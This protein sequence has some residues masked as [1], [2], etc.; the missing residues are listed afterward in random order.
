[1]LPKRID[2]KLMQ[3]SRSNRLSLALWIAVLG[4]FFVYLI[5]RF[6]HLLALP[7]FIDE[8]EVIAFAQD[9]Y[10]GRFFTGAA[11]GRLLLVWYA[12]LFQMTGPA[13]LWITRGIT[14]LFAMVNVAVIYN[15][16]QRWA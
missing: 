5:T 16:G 1:M 8:H 2:W 10:R 6:Y 4:V 7:P 14:A 9:V 13:V 11:Q 12:S 15:L 3:N